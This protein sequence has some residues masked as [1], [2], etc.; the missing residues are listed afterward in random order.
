MVY[1]SVQDRP[2]YKSNELYHA[3]HANQEFDPLETIINKDKLNTA[4]IN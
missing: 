4:V 1:T 3:Q 2:W